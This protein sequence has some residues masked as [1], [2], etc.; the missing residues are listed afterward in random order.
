MNEADGRLRNIAN[1]T[2]GRV[3][4]YLLQRGLEVGTFQ[5]QV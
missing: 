5:N 1:L 3:V 4:E 2:S